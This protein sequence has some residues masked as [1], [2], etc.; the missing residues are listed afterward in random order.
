MASMRW[1]AAALQRLARFA[2]ATPGLRKAL[3]RIL[4]R[5]PRLKRR[6]RQSLAR[7]STI[8]WQRPGPSA[9]LHDDD[10]LLSGVG[11][12]V[13]RDLRRER[14]RVDARRRNA[15]RNR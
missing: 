14:E 3:V 15:A 10:A 1:K 7:A 12:R 4:D 5:A 9:D 11:R 2:A 6:L 13:L 8:T